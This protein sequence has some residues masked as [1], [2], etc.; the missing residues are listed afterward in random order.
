MNKTELTKQIAETLNI[1]HTESIRYFNA[2]QE[3]LTSELERE[4]TI[5][6]QGF[7]TFT[8]WRQN[9]RPGRNPQN[10]TPCVIRRRLSVKFKPGK[11][12]LEAMN[13]KGQ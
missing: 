6:L 2:L 5:I 9:E 7:G 10:G 13:A 3:V 4:G 12:L 8:P 11:Y 1:P